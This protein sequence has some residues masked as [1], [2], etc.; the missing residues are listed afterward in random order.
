MPMTYKSLRN[1]W[2][3][4]LDRLASDY[5]VDLREKGLGWHSLRHFYGWYC[6][7]VLKHS[8]ER[9]STFL[10]HAS[11]ESTKVY[12]KL[13][14]LTARNELTKKFLANLGYKEEDINFLMTPDTP[15]LE[16]PG[17]WMNRQL[18]RKLQEIDYKMKFQG[19][20]S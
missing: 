11:L 13:S 8:L 16:F 20:A 2:T 6:A 7:S 3:R 4:L 19:K 17:D 18:H 15:K 12:Y 1:V 5:G 14:K 9:T 10:H